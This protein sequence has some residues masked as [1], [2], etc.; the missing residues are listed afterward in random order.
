[1]GLDLLKRVVRHNDVE[2]TLSDREA[3]LLAYL[4]RH[5]EEELTR[6]Q[7]IE[8]VWGDDA[9]GEGDGSGED[10]HR[11][12]AVEEVSIGLDLLHGREPSEPI[13]EGTHVRRVADVLTQANLDGR[14]EEPCFEPR[15]G[16]VVSHRRD[17]PLPHL[18]RR[19]DDRLLDLG[20]L[21]DRRGD[22]L[23]PF[24]VDAFLEV[25]GEVEIR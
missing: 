22:A 15:E 18:P 24:G 16:R 21:G 3:A 2:T 7:L 11:R 19:N 1:M 8:E 23:R 9:E 13:G 25:H 12:K 17:E 4:M 5:P 10:D 20:E 14:R 6:T